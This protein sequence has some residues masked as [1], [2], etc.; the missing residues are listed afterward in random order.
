MKSTDSEKQIS[1]TKESQSMELDQS[2]VLL[3]G[4]G[5]WDNAISLGI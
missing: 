1:G 3:D 2:T 5:F 4:I